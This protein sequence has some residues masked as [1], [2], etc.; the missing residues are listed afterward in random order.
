MVVVAW[1]MCLKLSLHFNTAVPPTHRG[2]SG[3]EVS[4][5]K[6]TSISREG[7]PWIEVFHII[8][9]HLPV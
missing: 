8:L 3:L 2:G 1:L 6:Y 9:Y 7:F 5:S 4:T